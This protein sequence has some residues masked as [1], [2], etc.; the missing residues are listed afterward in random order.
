MSDFSVAL[1]TGGAGFIGSH[2]VDRLLEEGFRVRVVDNFFSGDQKNLA[3]HKDNKLFEFVDGD[4]RNFDLVK[5]IIKD[6]DFVFHQAA[7]VSVPR[8]CEDP[9]LS[10]EI[11]I[12]GTLNLLQACVDSDVERFVFASSCAIYGDSD[13]LPIKEDFPI[14]PLS[15]YAIDKYACEEYAR[16][17][18]ETYGLETVGL[19]YFNVYGPRQKVGSYSGVISVFVNCFLDNK[20]PTVFGDGNQSRDFVHVKDVVNANLLALAKENISG[21][22]FNISSGKRISINSIIKIIKKVMNK[23]SEVFYAEPRS[24]DIEHSFANIEK[25]QNRLGYNPSVNF[26]EGLREVVNWYSTN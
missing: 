12:L 4:I 5:K 25:A 24:G 26:E 9:V 16:I 17:F 22:V 20:S 10:N 11:N 23:K 14:K 6:I 15:P 8:S 1:V 2:L 7:L 3:Q 19:R 13:I 21:E 18:S